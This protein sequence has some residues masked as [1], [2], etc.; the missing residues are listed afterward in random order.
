MGYNFAGKK[1]KVYKVDLEKELVQHAGAFYKRISR[2]WMEEDSCPT[3]PLLPPLISTRISFT[4]S[5]VFLDCSSHPPWLEPL[6][7]RIPQSPPHLDPRRYL[8]K[9][10]RVLNQEKNRV[11][12][13]LNRVTQ[14]PLNRE[15][16]VQLL[17]THQTELLSKK[18]GVRARP[19]V[20]SGRLLL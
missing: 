19:R 1:L 12:H 10:E 9:A 4:T 2:M 8:E 5:L 16:Y 15:C 7:L 6:A 13:Y 18:T 20:W 11:D 3:Y 14:E 17:K